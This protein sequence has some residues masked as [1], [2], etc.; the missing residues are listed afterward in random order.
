MNPRE[1]KQSV[2]KSTLRIIGGLLRSRRLYFSAELGVRP[3]PNRIRET[4]FNWLSGDIVGAT[5]LDLFA[6]SGSLGFEAISR[7]ASYCLMLDSCKENINF[8]EKSR[9]LFNI[10]NVDIVH[11]TFPCLANVSL[12]EFDIVFIDPPFHQ[13]YIPQVFKW[14]IDSQCLKLKTKLY[15]ETESD[16]DILSLPEKWRLIKDKIAGNVRYSL[17]E[18]L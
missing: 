11:A 17:I 3:T 14:L 6:G 16:E 15:I 13:G 8:L 18:C 1:K 12:Q 7:G 5:C 4:L 2:K 10:N 9:Q